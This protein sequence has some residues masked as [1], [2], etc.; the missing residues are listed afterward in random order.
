M[1][2]FIG[3]DLHTRYQVVAWIDEQTGEIRR[4]RLERQEKVPGTCE[5]I[6]STDFSTTYF[7]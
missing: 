6:G 2:H 3:N 4:C 1:Q 5:K 7:Q